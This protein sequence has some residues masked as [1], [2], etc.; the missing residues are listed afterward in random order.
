MLRR[1]LSSAAGQLPPHHTV[2]IPASLS[3]VNEYR[4]KKWFIREGDCVAPEQNMCSL[5]TKQFDNFLFTSS[6][7]E[8]VYV[9][10]RLVKEKTSNLREGNVL[11]VLV[12]SK[13]LVP[14]FAKCTFANFNPQY[15]PVT[16]TDAQIRLPRT[17][18]EN[19]RKM[20]L[21]LSANKVKLPILKDFDNPLE[22]RIDCAELVGIARDLLN[23]AKFET[24]SLR[25]LLFYLFAMYDVSEQYRALFIGSI[26]A[27]ANEIA[28]RQ[29]TSFTNIDLC[30][31][32]DLF[33]K[34]EQDEQQAKF[35][36]SAL[37][38]LETSRNL[39]TFSKRE[40]QS[41]LTTINILR[42]DDGGGA[43]HPLRLTILEKLHKSK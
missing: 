27:I 35:L 24:T 5:T 32:I 36:H 12:T 4:L 34:L 23:K 33:R 22:N 19:L 31:T 26:E 6:F 30:Q 14:E 11:A 20:C 41:I 40:L 25:D 21:N 38:E 2:T 18:G 9:A 28:S 8:N 29:L 39:S 1:L 17:V 3:Q 16:T 37:L 15:V 43:D 42:F 7:P 13:D 10:K